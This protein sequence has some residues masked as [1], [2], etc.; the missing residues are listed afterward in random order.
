VSGLTPF[1]TVGPFFE[2]GMCAHGAPARLST[3]ETVGTP[4]I[5]EGTL[6]DGAGAFV[7]DAL[8]EVWQANAF[9]KYQHPD[10]HSEKPLDAAFDG[11][12]RA[13]TN[14]QGY[15]RIETIKPGRV[16]GQGETL[17]APHLLLGIFARGLL[18]RL[19]TRVYFGDE[20]SNVD[21]TILCLVPA[22][23]RHTLIAP[24]VAPGRYRFDVRLQGDSESETVF[25][26]V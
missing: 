26:D 3:D 2:V 16:E 17:Q 13:P 15:F 4:I 5:V 23:R 6:R 14:D 22:D 24:L 18:C 20:A 11:F 8:I 12:A 19:V 1:Q 21:D 10:D 7:P 25:F 9:G